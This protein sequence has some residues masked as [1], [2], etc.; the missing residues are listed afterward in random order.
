M[1]EKVKDVQPPH[2]LTRLVWRTP[3]W[4]YR[5]GFGGLL[6]ERFMLLNHVGRKSGKV[7]KTVVEVVSRDSVSGAYI[8][9]SGFGDKADWYRNVIAHPNITVQVGRRRI[10]AHAERLPPAPAAAALLDYNRRHPAALRN[11]AR[12]MG[13]RTDGSEADVRELAREVPVLAFV[14]LNS[15]GELLA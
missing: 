3:I 12:L 7:R 13:F 5:L 4:L 14:P 11:L 2:G 8:A 1:L 15:S 10:P 6:G 9:V